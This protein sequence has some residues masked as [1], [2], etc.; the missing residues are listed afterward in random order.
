MP[1][2]CSQTV[3]RAS[4]TSS[5][6]WSPHDWAGD[7]VIYLGSTIHFGGHNT[8]ADQWR[9]G[10]HL[11]YCLGW[12]RTEENNYLGTPPSV[13]ATLSPQ[14]QALIGYSIH[15]AISVGG[16]YL[17]MVDMRNPLDMLADGTL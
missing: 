17:G 1:C 8:T 16:G 5:C 6:H 13:A 15:D 7:A 11:S 10:V 3:A 14:A 2:V 4:M 9:R 12:L